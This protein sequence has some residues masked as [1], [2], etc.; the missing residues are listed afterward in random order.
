MKAARLALVILFGVLGTVRAEEPNNPEIAVHERYLKEAKLGTDD[1]ALL[2]IIRSRTFTDKQRTAIVDQVRL[3]GDRK[4]AVR[5]QAE[6]D[7]IKVGKVAIP[8]LKEALQDSDPEVAKRAARCLEAIETGGDTSILLSAITLLRLRGPKGTIDVLLTYL[9]STGDE[10]VVDAIHTALAQVGLKKD[11]VA[12]ELVKALEASEKSQRAAAA[13]VVAR[14]T[15]KQRE[16]LKPL[17]KAKEP[18]VRLQAAA[19]LLRDGDKEAVEVV[20]QLLNGTPMSIAVQ[21]EEWLCRVAGAQ[22][23]GVSLGVDEK[24]RQACQE[25]WTAWWKA[26][27]DKLDWK[28]V[29][30]DQTYLGLTLIG[31]SQ[32]KNGGGQ[33]SEHSKDGKELWKLDMKGP[34]D[35]Q[36]LPGERLL[37]G[38]YNGGR[39]VEVDRTGKVLWESPKIDSVVAVQRLSNG[40]TLVGSYTRVMEVARDG[41]VVSN[42]TKIHSSSMYYATKLRSGNVMC[43]I[44]SGELIELDAAGKEVWRLNV[45][46]FSKWAGVEELP[47]GNLLLAKAG[48]DEVVEIDRNNKVLWRVKVANP[49]SATRLS[50]GHTLVCSHDDQMVYEFDRQG[51]EVW[52][53]KV[54]G[55]PFRARRR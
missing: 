50:N 19:G 30:F 55:R 32:M 12:E 45:G 44:S 3:L 47:N 35:V 9:P 4:F 27:G 16:A 34:M 28:K 49:N 5:E 39:A 13:Y 48:A 22:S 14:S 20:L 15:P 18:E 41:K 29:Q 21:A 17:L 33:V 24:A 36:V 7:L 40:N 37:I 52:K 53:Y 38:D 6:K 51:K 8:R 31:Q 25:A 43:A 26:N 11:Q 2:E 10:I 54:E 46:G 23:P 42:W 1:A